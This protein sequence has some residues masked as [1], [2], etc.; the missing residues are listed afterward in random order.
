MS[1]CTYDFTVCVSLAMTAAAAAAAIAMAR[2]INDYCII[3][4]CV[5]SVKKSI[6][7]KCE[8]F[9]YFG[10]K[11]KDSHKPTTTGFYATTP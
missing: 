3:G 8:W 11:Y 6:R 5:R 9:E 4:W 2:V 7:D 10:V 1:W